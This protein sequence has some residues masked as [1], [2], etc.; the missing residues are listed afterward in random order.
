MFLKRQGAPER[1]RLRRRSDPESD[2]SSCRRC[3]ARWWARARMETEGVQRKRIRHGRADVLTDRGNDD[4]GTRSPQRSGGLASAAV[5]TAAIVPRRAKDS[6]LTGNRFVAGRVGRVVGCRRGVPG[7]H[8]QRRA[9]A[10][11]HRDC[12]ENGEDEIAYPPPPEHVSSISRM[13]AR[14]FGARKSSRSGSRRGHLA[15]RSASVER[16]AQE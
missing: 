1:S 6:S 9:H 13:S 7:R 3:G 11:G 8:A 15:A 4:V 2:G 14:G 16:I 10:C 5:V 12:G